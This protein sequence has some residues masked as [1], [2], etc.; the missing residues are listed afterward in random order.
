MTNEERILQENRYI[1]G[2]AQAV[3]R[4][5]DI[6][7]ELALDL[8]MDF[9]QA[10]MESGGLF[11]AAAI[12][13]MDG[14]MPDQYDI[15]LV[16][17]EDAPAELYCPV[18]THPDYLKGFLEGQEDGTPEGLEQVNFCVLRFEQVAG[19]LQHYGIDNGIPSP[20]IIINC[21]LDSEWV[22]S[23]EEIAYVIESYHEEY[24][25]MSEDELEET[26]LLW[27]VEDV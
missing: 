17:E 23:P 2:L 14:D 19:L 15:Y 8:Q 27:C 5:E 6:S 4:V 20:G 9:Y 24:D 13:G 12:T 21:G 25:S 26:H 16:N 11:A 10:L 1:E 18:F 7:E 3:D 22:L